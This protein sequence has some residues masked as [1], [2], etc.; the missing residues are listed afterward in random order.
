M[1]KLICLIALAIIGSLFLFN[2]VSADRPECPGNSCQ[3]LPTKSHGCNGVGNPH[4]K[5]PEPAPPDQPVQPTPKPSPVPVNP[6]PRPSPI[7]PPVDPTPDD[8]PEPNPDVGPNPDTGPNPESTPVSTPLPIDLVDNI[9]SECSDCCELDQSEIELNLAK[10]RLLDALTEQ[11][12]L[13]NITEVNI[14]IN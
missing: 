5:T 7:S 12:E 8:P 13:G 2:S 3:P 10:A 1:K 6:T 9:D 4:C 14:S 11:I